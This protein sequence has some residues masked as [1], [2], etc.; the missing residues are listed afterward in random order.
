MESNTELC[1]H[2]NVYSECDKTI[3]KHYTIYLVRNASMNSSG[4]FT[5]Y[6]NSTYAME[7]AYMLGIFIHGE[8][9]ASV[10][11]VIA[12]WN[13]DRVEI[14]CHG[15]A[16]PYPLVM[17]WVEQCI[18]NVK[19]EPVCEETIHHDH[20]QCLKESHFDYLSVEFSATFSANGPFISPH[21]IRCSVSNTE[22]TSNPKGR[23]IVRNFPEQVRLNITTPFEELAYGTVTLECQADVYD[24][25]NHFVFVS[26]GTEYHVLGQRDGF[27]WVAGYSMDFHSEKIVTCMA[28]LKT[29]GYLNVSKTLPRI[30][31]DLRFV[32][33]NRSVLIALQPDEKVILHCDATGY[34]V[35]KI[36]WLRDGILQSHNGSMIN[37]SV[38]VKEESIT[39][40]CLASNDVMQISKTWRISLISK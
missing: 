23:L 30:L 7:K 40:L 17:C 5:L 10:D 6:I 11:D 32:H 16:Y 25:T 2:F 38:S 24:F 13:A 3:G 22:G 33:G 39:F 35:P 31:Y 19:T 34:P 8:P 9:R 26:N 29:G 14:T 18:E 27:A 1:E 36:A 4:W 12:L 28:N 21:S 37:A 20:F 15:Q